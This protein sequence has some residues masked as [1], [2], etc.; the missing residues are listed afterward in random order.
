MT[1]RR[2]GM[3]Q[4]QIKGGK[5]REEHEKGKGHVEKYYVR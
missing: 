4:K 5:T 3:K 2:K 1:I